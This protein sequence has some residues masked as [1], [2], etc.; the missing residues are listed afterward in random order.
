MSNKKVSI[1]VPAL[2]EELT[3]GEFIGWCKEGL[4]KARVE[5]EIIIVD[6]STDRTP[7]IAESMGAR[8]LR[9]PKRGLGQAYIDAIPE[10]KGDYVIMGDCDCTYDFREIGNFIEKLDEGYEYVMGTRM[11]GYIEKDAMPKLHQYFGTPLT[12]KILNVVYGSK[13]SDIHCGMRGMTLDALKKISLESSSWEYASE[14]VLKSIKLRLKVTEVPIRFYKDRE[15]RLS[16]HK[17]TGWFSPWLAGWINLRVM[18]EYTPQ[19]FLK[20]PGILM[21][22]IGFVFTAIVFWNRLTNT[23]S[24]FALHSLLFGVLLFVV[25][26]S[27]YQSS[28]LAEIYYGFDPEK[29]KKY[30]RRI[31]YN[32]MMLI[33][34]FLGVAGIAF[35]VYFLNY[36]IKGGFIMTGIAYSLIFSIVSFIVCFQTFTFALLFQMLSKKRYDQ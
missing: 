14:M 26:L 29:T 7:E 17:R 1:V 25:G 2:N 9:V 28:I 3:I 12:T 5:G 22:I 33:A 30:R 20:I 11:K 23:D 10:I 15:G 32:R 34:F 19:T 21:S 35:A 4:E 24:V 6:S 8:V 16:H 31:S 13:Y 36:F 18:L 27:F